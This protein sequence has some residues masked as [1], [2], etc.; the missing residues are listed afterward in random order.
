[1]IL[2]KNGGMKIERFRAVLFDCEIL[3]Q[4]KKVFTIDGSHSP[5]LLLLPLLF[6]F[7]FH[8]HRPFPIS[9]WFILVYPLDMKLATKY[10]HNMDRAIR[11]PWVQFKYYEDFHLWVR[12]LCKRN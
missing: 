11:E 5:L 6:H 8:Y 7:Y 2:I 1:M 9:F 10:P 12:L 3:L 4:L